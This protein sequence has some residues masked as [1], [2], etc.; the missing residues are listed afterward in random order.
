MNGS[1][2]RGRPA[3]ITETK[4]MT[5]TVQ[6]STP[7][8]LTEAETALVLQ[9]SKA[10]LRTWRSRG[11]GPRFVKT[12]RLVRYRPEELARYADKNTRG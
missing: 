6:L 7:T 12:G 11:R 5:Q 8:F 2:D 4:T 3:A 10:T 9:V 1:V